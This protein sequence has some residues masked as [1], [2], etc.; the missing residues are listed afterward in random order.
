MLDVFI[1]VDTEFWC[2]TFN[3]TTD[4]AVDSFDKFINGV[5]DT[6]AWGVP[7]QVDLLRKHDLKAVFFVEGLYVPV[8]CPDQSQKLVELIRA[9]GHDV[10]IHAHTEWLPCLSDITLSQ[11]NGQDIR[12]FNEDDQT[13]ILAK[14]I[15]NLADVGVSDP[16]AF[17]AGNFG[18]NWTTLKAL[19][20]NGIRID[21]SLNSRYL[22]TACDMHL[23]STLLQPMLRNRVVEFPVGLFHDFPG[24]IRPLHIQA[25]SFSEMR[26]VLI[27]YFELGLPTCVLVTHSFETLNSKRTGPDPIVCRRFER[28]CNF[29]DENRDKFRTVGFRDVADLTIF[30][31][32]APQTAIP[33]SSV[34]R[35]GVRVAEQLIRR[36]IY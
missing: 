4:E 11:E 24:H 19:A 23:D 32:P 21:S 26:H 7:Y 1:T 33:R 3:P 8:A 35:T 2:S 9:N 34:F 6:G 30:D 17:R 12:L 36:A 5:T 31:A 13:T 28:L 14:A 16:V 29:L 20:R 15:R 25:C 18:A 22:G 10:E 27:E